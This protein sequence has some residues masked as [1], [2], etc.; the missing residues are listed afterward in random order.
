MDE[1]CGDVR[2]AWGISAKGYFTHC[3]DDLVLFGSTYVFIF[4]LGS[5]R[6]W[7]LLHTP[8]KEEFPYSSRHSVKVMVLGW[9]G[10]FPMIIFAAKYS[11]GVHDDFEWVAKPLA[12]LAWLY[13]LWILNMEVARDLRECWVLKTFWASSIV[14]ATAALPTVVLAAET[15][16]YGA[17]FYAYLLH[18]VLYLAIVLLA[19]RFPHYS[20]NE[21]AEW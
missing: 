11:N 7:T 5:Y 8:T 19:F 9:L 2:N 6:A 15:N 18:Y 16:G 13:S 20:Q 1:F 17:T 3:F 4:V 21:V 10:L 14:A 12:S